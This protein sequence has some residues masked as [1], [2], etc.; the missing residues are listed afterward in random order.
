MTEDEH[1]TWDERAAHF[2]DWGTPLRPSASD[3]ALYAAFVGERFAGRRTPVESLLLGVTPEL[4]LMRWP[5]PLGLTAIDHSEP[6]VRRVWPGDLP[7]ERRALVGDWMHYAPAAPP[8]LV[9]TDGAP[10]FFS[11]PETL[12]ARVRELLSP[13]GMFIVRAF[14]APPARE[15]LDAVLADAQAGRVDSFHLFKWRVAM[16]MQDDAQAGVAQH[17][18]WARCKDMALDYA[19]LPQPG[20]SAR[21]VS[22]LRFYE[23]QSAR[24]HFPTREQYAQALGRVFGTVRFANPSYACGE[25]FTVFR[26]DGHAATTH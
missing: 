12:F 11:R 14:C 4:A 21:A 26:A 17:A 18:V 25:R 6:M 8:E 22:T 5:V 9:L 2:D 1:F 24:L 19:A 15:H 3:L 23:G 16:A 7:G 10:V 20:F 13:Q